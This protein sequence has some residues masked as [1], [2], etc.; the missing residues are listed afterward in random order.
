MISYSD[1]YYKGSPLI[2]GRFQSK[3]EDCHK[4]AVQ[5][6]CDYVIQR[7]RQT[8]LRSLGMMVN[9]YLYLVDAL[10]ILATVL[11]VLIQ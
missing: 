6:R 8:L 11:I 2:R 1:L 10:N 3:Q 5:I 4:L 7:A 9:F